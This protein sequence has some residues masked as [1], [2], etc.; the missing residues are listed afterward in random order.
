MDVI[1]SIWACGEC[2]TEYPCRNDAEN[3]KVTWACPWAEEPVFE[4][5]HCPYCGK[6]C[7]TRVDASS[8]CFPYSIS[9]IAT[10]EELEAAG[11]QRIFL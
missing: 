5:V 8:C 6:I 3:C 7:E 9:L 10:P 4:V 11:Q 2:G 1:E